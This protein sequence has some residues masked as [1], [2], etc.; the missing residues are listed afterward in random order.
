MSNT[1]A[2]ISMIAIIVLVIVTVAYRHSA[3]IANTESTVPISQRTAMTNL[4]ARFY[5]NRGRMPTTN[6]DAFELSALLAQNG[7]GHY[8]VKVL[9]VSYHGQGFFTVKVRCLGSQSLTQVT[10]GVSV[11]LNGISGRTNKVNP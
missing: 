4:V 9:G 1:F 5:E 7:M 8:K 2:K 10:L 11:H 3:P 6:A